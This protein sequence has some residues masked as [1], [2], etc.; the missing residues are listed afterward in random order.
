MWSCSLTLR[1]L[2]LPFVTNSFLCGR[3]DILLND[4]W[5]NSMTMFIL[6]VRRYAE[7]S[8]V[9]LHLPVFIFK[10]VSHRH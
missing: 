7:W 10:L 2:L 8:V 4:T 6:N 5:L 1:L 9:H 3:R